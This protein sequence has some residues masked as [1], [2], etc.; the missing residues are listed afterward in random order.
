MTEVIINADDFGISSEVN[1]AVIKMYKNGNLNSASIIVAG[2]YAQ[3]AINQALLSPGL[4][5]GLHFNLTTGQSRSFFNSRNLLVNKNNFFKFGFIQLLLISIFKRIEFLKEVETE[6]INQIRYIKEFGV[7][8]SHID[9]HRHIHYIPGILKIVR[10]I[11]LEEKIPRIRIINESLFHT[12]FLGKLPSIS[13]IIK[14]S[15]LKV[16]GLINGT[17]K[18][19]S[20]VYFFS[21]IHSCRVTN[22]LFKKFSLQKEYDSLEIMLHP[23]LN[24]L[25]SQDLD[26]EKNHLSSK[27]R[28]IE[29]QFIKPNL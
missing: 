22:S 26:Y 21:I 14:W 3:D 5:I 19:K 7:V 23:S 24:I 8:L 15:V 12:L 9:G 4:K 16:L 29:S 6:L 13:G 17:Y 28:I 1:A 27:Y 25:N 11:A 10:K 18:I 20:P 2:K